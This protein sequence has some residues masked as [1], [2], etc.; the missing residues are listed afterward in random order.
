MTTTDML[1][2]SGL[3]PENLASPL[4]GSPA[5]AEGVTRRVTQDAEGFGGGPPTLL[6][7]AEPD[8]PLLRT[9]ASQSTL[10]AAA[11]SSLYNAKENGRARVGWAIPIS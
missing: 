6:R 7:R 3:A 1:P 8:G 9:A 4:V 2:H 10:Y 11:D 5:Q